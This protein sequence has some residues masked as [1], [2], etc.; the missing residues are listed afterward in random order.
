[1][2]EAARWQSITAP[3]VPAGVPLLHAT[4]ARM[5]LDEA[6]VR[7]DNTDDVATTWVFPDRSRLY[8]NLRR[9]WVSKE[10]VR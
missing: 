10:V 9:A 6:A 3:M 5:L 7:Q 1:M 4:R 2:T 8:A